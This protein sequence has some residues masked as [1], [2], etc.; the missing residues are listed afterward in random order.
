[1]KMRYLL[2]ILLISQASLS[3]F[4]QSMTIRNADKQYAN[5]HYAD[6]A[7]IYEQAIGHGEG[8][9]SVY[10]KLADS[11]FKIKDTKNAE[12]YYAKVTDA[13]DEDKL[14]QYAQSLLQNGKYDEAKKLL[15]GKTLTKTKNSKIVATDF[16]QLKNNSTAK[17]IYFMDFNSPYADF[18]AVPYE[19]GIVF[20]SSRK[21]GSL[22][23]NVFGWNNTPFLN[24][25]YLD[26]TGISKKAYNKK[27]VQEQYLQSTNKLYAYD[28]N[29]HTDETKL[30][31]NDVNTLG[32]YGS[33]ARQGDTLKTGHKIVPFVAKL[34][35][36]YHD[37]PI[38][39]TPTKDLAVFTRNDGKSKDGVS[40]LKLFSS[41]KNNADWS[42]PKSLPFNSNEYSVGHAAFDA[43]GKTMYFASDMPGGQGGTDIYKVSYDNGSW[44]KPENLGASVNT[45]GNELFPFVT[46]NGTLLFSSDGHGGLGGLEVLA[47][48]LKG[49]IKNLGYP[50]NTNKDDFGVCMNDKATTGFLSSN[51]NRDGIDDDIYFFELKKPISFLQT[52]KLLVVDRLTG[53]PIANTNVIPGDGL[54]PTTTNENGFAVFEVEAGKEYSFIGKKQP[55]N[56][57]SAKTTIKEMEGDN[58]LKLY[59]EA[60]NSLYLLVSDRLTNAPLENVKVKIANKNTNTTLIDQATPVTGDV[61]KELE[62]AKVGDQLTY[63]IHL[64]REGYLSKTVTFNYKIEKPGEIPVHE[65]LDIKMDKIELGM[66]VGKVINI[67]PIYFDLNKSNIR[68][69]A[70]K[71]LDKIVQVMTDN[72]NMVIEL[73]SHTDCR[74]S[75]AYNAALSDRRAKASAEYVTLK[76]IDKKRIYGKGYGE[77][78]LVNG[79]ACEGAVKPN[80]SEAEHQLNRRTEFVIVKM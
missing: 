79:C 78:K 24:L 45:D 48:N 54:S 70:S 33:Y 77:S 13:F 23:K 7:D 4:A 2:F 26:T 36:K 10:L 64:E 31:S 55:Y 38:A 52:L 50:I 63:A 40:K 14:Y 53:K 37:G 59:L 9:N 25:L 60:G 75:A 27:I 65:F 8:S 73:G 41:T 42:S 44:G 19:K 61:R 6:A 35:T 43:S 57:G 20:A 69:D 15:Q 5:M 29:L 51:R 72:P 3:S 56:D 58:E 76:G 12:K 39:F 17:A 74:S 22:H 49:Q 46:S 67:N 30:T 34:N 62:G 11:Y 21:K 1:M 80:C 47:T 32:Y 28:K 18:S 66:D 68:P 16:N 71:E